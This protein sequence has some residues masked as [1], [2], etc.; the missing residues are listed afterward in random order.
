M[1]VRQLTRLFG[2]EL[3]TTPA[4]YVERARV[5]RAKNLLETGDQPLDAVAR[6]SGFGSPETMRRAFVRA[7]GVTPAAYRARFR[8]TGDG[9]PS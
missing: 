7:L 8:S 6:R 1:S 9:H 4:R 3:G 5:E 2:K